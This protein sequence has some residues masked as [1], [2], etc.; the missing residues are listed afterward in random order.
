MAPIVSFTNTHYRKNVIML[1]ARE[2]LSLLRA[3]FLTTCVVHG[4]DYNDSHLLTSNLLP[5]RSYEMKSYFIYDTL[6]SNIESMILYPLGSTIF[7]CTIEPL[8]LALY[9]PIFTTLQ[10][11]SE[12]IALM[13][14]KSSNMSIKNLR[15][16]QQHLIRS[17]WYKKIK[18]IGDYPSEIVPNLYLGSKSYVHV[19]KLKIGY[20]VRL[21]LSYPPTTIPYTQYSIWDEPSQMSIV[22]LEEA[23]DVVYQQIKKGKRV[24]VHCQAGVSRSSTV[25]LAYLMKHHRMTLAQAFDLTFKVF[26]ELYNFNT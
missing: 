10:C 15:L 5:Y 1:P 9:S 26:K 14:S 13:I 21:G 3:N 24:L 18:P 16:K 7:Y 25:V 2:W 20:I 19:K 17:V 4:Q 8:P 12:C 6:I 22:M 11:D 23:V